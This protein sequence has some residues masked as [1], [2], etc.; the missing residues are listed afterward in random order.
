MP[1]RL[2]VSMPLAAFASLALLAAPSAR[3][4]AQT[5]RDSTSADSGRRLP[6]VVVTGG[7][8]GV[9]HRIAEVDDERRALLAA[10]REN[11]ALRRRLERSDRAID[12][13]ERHLVWLR[14]TVTDSLRREIAHLD[15]AA[16]DA[17]A[18]R[19]ALEA[20]VRER[21]QASAPPDG[22]SR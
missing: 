4:G 19:E 21:E 3:A 13:L 17:R 11:R 2:L 6:P 9:F 20:R 15:S 18:E 7:G 10:A 16:A 5:V 8:H 1:R 12:S 22:G 14:T